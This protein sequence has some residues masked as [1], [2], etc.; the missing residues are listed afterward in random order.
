M[1]YPEFPLSGA[2]RLCCCCLSVCGQIYTRA[3]PQPGD[4]EERASSS[5]PCSAR[6]FSAESSDMSPDSLPAYSWPRKAAA[7]YIVLLV[8]LF[9]S[10]IQQYALCSLG[11][12]STIPLELLTGDSWHFSADTPTRPGCTGMF[13]F[14][15][16]HLIFAHG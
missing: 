15:P 3:V 11:H 2:W 14:R 9:N 10:S 7:P 16:S 5:S 1:K 6:T 13:H 4:R 8:C 12:V